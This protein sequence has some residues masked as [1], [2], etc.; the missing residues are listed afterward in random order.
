VLFCLIIMGAL[1]KASRT[2]F[3]WL[4]NSKLF[5]C[6]FILLA[7]MFAGFQMLTNET[8]T[9]EFYLWSRQMQLYAIF[10]FF[11]EFI[12]R[13]CAHG[14]GGWL[15][16]D[17]KGAEK[18]MLPGCSPGS[19]FYDLLFYQNS[20]GVFVEFWTLL[21]LFVLVEQVV[22]YNN[23]EFPNVIVLKALS[24]CKILMH[25]SLLHIPK[26][27]V[28]TAFESI[29]NLA[30]LFVSSLF[31]ALLFAIMGMNLFGLS[32]GMRKFCARMHMPPVAELVDGAVIYNGSPITDDQLWQ[33]MARPC[34][35]VTNLSI[36]SVFCDLSYPPLACDEQSSSICSTIAPN[37]VCVLLGLP[38]G[39][40]LYDFESLSHAFVA[41]ITSWYFKDF[42][43]QMDVLQQASPGWSA[44][45]FVVC[46]FMGGFVLLNLTVATTSK[47]YTEVRNRL[48]N[49]KQ[50]EEA[51]VLEEKRVREL[52]D[53]EYL[54]SLESDGTIIPHYHPET[55]IALW[56]F[57]LLPWL[58]WIYVF[59]TLTALQ[60]IVLILRILTFNFLWLGW[61]LDSTSLRV[62]VDVANEK[63]TQQKVQEYLNSL[64]SK[65]LDILQLIRSPGSIVQFV[66]LILYYPLQKCCPSCRRHDFLFEAQMCGNK[67]C[68]LHNSPDLDDFYKM[69]STPR[70]L[71]TD[72]LEALF[73]HNLSYDYTV[74]AKCIVGTPL[75]GSINRSLRRLKRVQRI[76]DKLKETQY[77]E[78]EVAKRLQDAENGDNQDD[79]NDDLDEHDVGNGDSLDG[80]KAVPYFTRMTDFVILMNTVLLLFSTF[81]AADVLKYELAWLQFA[82]VL[83]FLLECLLR[84]I[85]IRNFSLYL[86]E[87]TNM[88]E[89]VLGTLNFVAFIWRISLE[90]SKS[91][92]SDTAVLL[93]STRIFQLMKVFMRYF[94]EDSYL[95]VWK[96]LKRGFGSVKH[97]FAVIFVNCCFLLVFSFIGIELF[98]GCIVDCEKSEYNGN[99]NL[100]TGVEN[101]FTQVHTA[102]VALFVL[103]T[104][105][106]FTSY[107]FYGNRSN[108]FGVFY[109]IVFY[110]LGNYVFLRIFVALIVYNYDIPEPER[111][112]IQRSHA[113][114]AQLNANLFEASE[115]IQT[116]APPQLKKVL[117]ANL[118]TS[119]NSISDLID[120]DNKD[121]YEKKDNEWIRTLALR[122]IA[123]EKKAAMQ[124]SSPEETLLINSL[125]VMYTIIKP[126]QEGDNEDAVL[127]QKR[128]V[129]LLN[130]PE[131]KENCRLMADK[132]ADFI[133]ISP[134]DGSDDTSSKKGFMELK[135]SS[136]EIALC[137][138]LRGSNDEGILVLE[139]AIQHTNPAL[140]KGITETDSRRRLSE[141]TRLRR[142]VEA[143]KV[144]K[145]GEEVAFERS[146]F[147]NLFAVLS[148]IL[149][150]SEKWAFKIS[151]HEPSFL[152][153]Y[154]TFDL[155]ALVVILFSVYLSIVKSSGLLFLGS[156]SATRTI[157]YVLVLFFIFEMLLRGFANGWRTQTPAAW[158]HDIDPIFR[159]PLKI[160]DLLVIF[161]MILDTIFSIP[162]PDSI[163]VVRVLKLLPIMRKL[164]IGKDEDTPWVDAPIK[165]LFDAV[166]NAVDELACILVFLVFVIILFAY[167]VSTIYPAG[168]FDSCND[169]SDINMEECIGVKYDQNGYGYLA[170]RYV[171]GFNQFGLDTDNFFEA[172]KTL[173]HVLSQDGWSPILDATMRSSGSFFWRWEAVIPFF[174]FF[175]FTYLT[176]VFV[177]QLF[178]GTFIFNIRLAQGDGLFT[179]TQQRWAATRKN[180]GKYLKYNKDKE[181]PKGWR[182][183]LYKLSESVYFQWFMTLIIIANVLFM[184]FE[185]YPPDPLFEPASNVI[186]SLFLS[187]F[188]TEITSKLFGYQFE[189]ITLW[190]KE[191][192]FIAKEVWSDGWVRFDVVVIALSVLDL[193]LIPLLN[194]PQVS[195]ITA[196]RS[197]RLVRLVKKYQGLQLICSTMWKGLPVILAGFSLMLLWSVIF[198]TIAVEF[199]GKIREGVVISPT[200]NF[201]T[202][203]GSL[204]LMFRIMCGDGWW[205]L[206]ND[207][208]VAKPYCSGPDCGHDWGAWFLIVYWLGHS[209]VFTPL[210]IASLI[211][212]F[213]QE[214]SDDDSYVKESD[215]LKYLSVWKTHENLVKR[216]KEEIKEIQE[217]WTLPE[218]AAKAAAS[219]GKSAHP[220]F[221][222]SYKLKLMHLKPLL[223]ALKDQGCALGF[224]P[225]E[226]TKSKI[227]YEEVE[228][229]LVAKAVSSFWSGITKDRSARDPD[230]QGFQNPHAICCCSCRTTKGSGPK[231]TGFRV[232]KFFKTSQDG[233]A[234]IEVDVDF[235]GALIYRTM[236]SSDLFNRWKKS[237]GSDDTSGWNEYLRERKFLMGCEILDFDTV[238][239]VL[240]SFLKESVSLSSVDFLNEDVG[241]ESMLKQSIYKSKNPET[242][243]RPPEELIENFRMQ[244]H[245]LAVIEHRLRSP[246]SQNSR[247]IER[248]SEAQ[249]H[250]WSAFDNEVISKHN[251]IQHSI[252]AGKI[253]ERFAPSRP[254]RII[255]RNFGLDDDSF[256]NNCPWM[257]FG[258]YINGIYLL[259]EGSS[260]LSRLVYN[261]I[262]S[263]QDINSF[264]MSVRGGDKQEHQV[265]VM[266]APARLR[267]P[268]GL[269]QCVFSCQ[270]EASNFFV[271]DQKI[272][273]FSDDDDFDIEKSDGILFSYTCSLECFRSSKVMYAGTAIRENWIPENAVTCEGTYVEEGDLCWVF[274]VTF[275][276]PEQLS[277]SLGSKGTSGSH[278]FIKSE[279]LKIP[280]A[281]CWS[282]CEKSINLSLPQQIHFPLHPAWYILKAAADPESDLSSDE[283]NDGELISGSELGDKGIAQISDRVSNAD[284]LG[285]DFDLVTLQVTLL[286]S[287]QG[288]C[289]QSA[290]DELVFKFFDFVAPDDDI[291]CRI[292]EAFES[293]PLQKITL[294]GCGSLKLNQN[295]L[296]VLPFV[297]IKDSKEKM[298][299]GDYCYVY[300]KE[301]FAHAVARI[302]KVLN[303]ELY[304][305]HLHSPNH[306]DT[307]VC[308]LIK[309]MF[310]D[311]LFVDVLMHEKIDPETQ[312]ISKIV[313]QVNDRPV[314]ISLSDRTIFCDYQ[315]PETSLKKCVIDGEYVA[316]QP[317]P[318]FT[319]SQYKR[320]GSRHQ[321]TIRYEPAALKKITV[322]KIRN[323]RG[324]SARFCC[325]FPHGLQEND[326]VQDFDLAFRRNI[327]FLTFFKIFRTGFELAYIEFK[328]DTNPEFRGKG[329]F[330]NFLKSERR[331]LLIQDVK[332]KLQDA[333]NSKERFEMEKWMLS[334]AVDVWKRKRKEA[335]LRIL[336]EQTTS[337]SKDDLH[338][339][340]NALLR[341][342][343]T[344]AGITLKEKRGFNNKKLPHQFKDLFVEEFR[345]TFQDSI[346]YGP[347]GVLGFLNWPYP[348]IPKQDDPLNR[349]N[350]AF[351]PFC[352]ID[353]ETQKELYEDKSA[354]QSEA[355]GMEYKVVDVT[356]TEFSLVPEP[357]MKKYAETPKSCP[358][359]QFKVHHCACCWFPDGF[360]DGFTLYAA[361][362][363]VSANGGPPLPVN[364]DCGDIPAVP[365]PFCE[366]MFQCVPE[367]FEGWIIDGHAARMSGP[368][369]Q[370]E[371]PQYL[372]TLNDYETCIDP[373]CAQ[374]HEQHATSEDTA[375]W[376]LMHGTDEQLRE[377]LQLFREP[378]ES[379]DEKPALRN[380]LRR[381]LDRSK[382]HAGLQPALQNGDEGDDMIN[383]ARVASSEKHEA[384]KDYGIFRSHGTGDAGEPEFEGA[385]SFCKK[386]L[387]FAEKELR[388]FPV[389]AAYELV[390]M[391]D[392]LWDDYAVNVCALTTDG[393]DDVNGN[394]HPGIFDQ[395]LDWA[396]SAEASNTAD[397]I[398]CHWS[399]PS[400]DAGRTYYESDISLPTGAALELPEVKGE[401][402][403]DSS[404]VLK[405]LE[406]GLPISTM[407]S[408]QLSIKREQEVVY[409]KRNLKTP[410][411]PTSGDVEVSAEGDVVVT[412]QS[413]S[414]PLPKQNPFAQLTN[415]ILSPFSRAGSSLSSS[416]LSM[417]DQ[418]VS[419]AD[420]NGA[421]DASQK[422]P[423]RKKR[424][425]VADR[426][427][428]A[429]PRGT[430][431]PASVVGVPGGNN[432]FSV[433]FAACGGTR[434]QSANAVAVAAPLSD[435][436]E[437]AVVV[438]KQKNRVKSSDQGKVS[439]RDAAEVE[440]GAVS[441]DEMDV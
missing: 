362:A 156:V 308:D 53:R 258:A 167:I 287:S 318:G 414:E 134:C 74:L 3:G 382:N 304:I 296:N 293:E 87:G 426:L 316:V 237:P 298:R 158:Q 142:Y 129:K 234:N 149:R 429:A 329:T 226:S 123:M 214:S 396:I 427:S 420:S 195:F 215:C 399:A 424:V 353:P 434:G 407:S 265:T 228:R 67:M 176:S 398:I 280:L 111:R 218:T 9:M 93:A 345:D 166:S 402:W 388:V 179:V 417:F 331:S 88:F 376:I 410:H 320:V 119:L 387:P 379:A 361:D 231:Q 431:E 31:W 395:I 122:N 209:L 439:G 289:A 360:P 229:M 294:S 60:R 128:K 168:S 202:F 299:P 279:T 241:T 267:K 336:E 183:V 405:L 97:V 14:F 325:M 268:S 389:N 291:E 386:S 164:Q 7:L 63:F 221:G 29:A 32:G 86:K 415:S 248:D 321:L 356:L 55:I 211:Q 18:W 5:D 326:T 96:V 198:G 352:C 187:L 76:I 130:S 43:S 10:I 354:F 355:G 140:V 367:T 327:H 401:S 54:K 188:L 22:A 143:L 90:L 161:L 30:P 317:D 324:K 290:P 148:E 224:D 206:L 42:M 273:A 82:L 70:G 343:N 269:G 216:T 245:S 348:G 374:F 11:A 377:T 242:W 136:D 368:F 100:Y 16:H 375:P 302:M 313:Q 205:G 366:Y 314:S 155:I 212:Y 200:D 172:T 27:I 365:I 233:A 408:E 332:E 106:L 23:P 440:S 1:A 199:F 213:T 108:F 33:P 171:S 315:T 255:A 239:Y 185:T 416:V 98:G 430:D 121:E 193:W 207:V 52:R 178:I 201:S 266:S 12:M 162:I 146:F 340:V 400:I 192:P 278:T 41:V 17:D 271:Q 99:A 110:F 435:A 189:T 219:S 247:T 384:L 131:F 390:R 305:E 191:I 25:V 236:S 392:N 250:D 2:A 383:I 257:D 301:I 6:V 286:Q 114:W 438:R 56:R 249:Y 147:E 333:K 26:V 359:I 311:G 145:V 364:I 135:R 144:L 181:S 312:K 85:A 203:F 174:L 380:R 260:G 391:R 104:G 204:M 303:V 68:D 154:S 19:F 132:I 283:A 263:D 335:E 349:E 288:Q 309:L 346:P 80:S 101:P 275:S 184:A 342:G 433:V 69:P 220:K 244:E 165:S 95:P 261:K 338:S 49:S 328:V 152:N 310:H 252:D 34:T 159:D 381:W 306:A 116:S 113:R 196:M 173:F 307:V 105:D 59:G 182:K 28:V 112:K 35:L 406:F 412:I 102:F 284:K 170:S 292:P 272:F 297:D 186:N 137:N 262:K 372:S 232:C 45:F 363:T 94:G 15:F 341:G 37:T 319:I 274:Y 13:L 371:V 139:E 230:S 61:L 344:G 246:E 322:Y 208:T 251:R 223:C 125:S 351:D 370:M 77:D 240:A 337:S 222:E 378:F 141:E 107:V 150:K 422:V 39:N 151:M 160:I 75:M 432:I 409:K 73:S 235:D 117:T 253:V 413:P 21:D 404:G 300:R 44:F 24:V 163:M 264:R 126:V 270:R 394:H 295:S 89:L 46:S 20:N 436:R 243:R 48:D 357:L 65:K 276:E 177:S 259:S 210:L 285:A 72:E 81:A 419:P 62:V 103:S 124:A 36:S 281:M 350:S 64:M 120:Y 347:D 66:N 197:L 109:W 358:R 175:M 227:K 71:S 84:F 79:E 40:L 334:H 437:A 256:A 428:C 91:I 180:L 238:C 373:F 397:A 225:M 83:F 425:S 411:R 51:Q 153:G 38:I 421:R 47:F 330:E 217:S 157:E 92:P 127:E 4:V 282:K 339:K 169:A 385:W 58:H 78:E 418:D 8:M 50:Q 277:K 194:L 254:L 133:G 423:R 393:Y 441:L 190:G 369:L 403:L 138:R 115:L 323:Q 57:F 118:L